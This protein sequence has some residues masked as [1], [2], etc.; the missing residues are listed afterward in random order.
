[1][2]QLGI[3]CFTSVARTQSFSATARELRI[4]QQAVSKHIRS[5]EE[6]LGFPLFLRSYQTV[7]L[8]HAGEQMLRYFAD[9]E[10]LLNDVQEHF[11]SGQ[12][13]QP[14][15]LAWSQWLGSPDWFRQAME[16][17]GS[18]HPHIP[19]ITCDLNA[20]ELSD[21]LHNGE[22]DLLLTT[23]YSARYLPVTWNFTP[24]GSE[25]IMHLASTG[26]D[27]GSG[28]RSQFPFFTTYAGESDEQDVLARVQRE[29]ERF[30]IRPNQIEICPNMGSV[31]LNI[32]ACGGSTLG[33]STPA[34]ARS[35]EFALQPTGH[36]ATV[37]L[38]RSFRKKRQEAELFERFLIQKL[39]G[40]T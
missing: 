14:L 20:E 1:M 34:L 36:S 23:R 2:N 39:E 24:I 9:R 13:V 22:I 30:G 31:Y 40:T 19:M 32:L 27:C 21:A 15:R 25:P 10:Q 18:T 3:L 28:D 33:V 5:L 12:K 4:S 29:C 37:V 26:A 6:E 16:D 7:H 8:T 17:F 38:C 35:G 11:R